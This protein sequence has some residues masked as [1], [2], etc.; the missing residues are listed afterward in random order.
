MQ[1]NTTGAL[2]E[3]FNKLSLDKPHYPLGLREMHTSVLSLPCCCFCLAGCMKFNSLTALVK[4]K[5]SLTARTDASVGTIST[6]NNVH[7]FYTPQNIFNIVKKNT[8]ITL[9]FKFINLLIPFFIYTC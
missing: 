3:T 9:H 1:Y 7:F 4:K 6:W 5:N 8:F 2:W